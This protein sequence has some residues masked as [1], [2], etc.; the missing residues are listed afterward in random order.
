MYPETNGI[1]KDNILGNILGCITLAN[2]SY[3][4]IF[5]AQEKG[6]GPSKGRK[7][8]RVQLTWHLKYSSCKSG[9]VKV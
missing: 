3:N 5:K 7:K 1:K 6:A 8:D 2:L 9:N 4:Q